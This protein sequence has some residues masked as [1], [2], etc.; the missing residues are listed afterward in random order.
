MDY[1]YINVLFILVQSR[2]TQKWNQ[3]ETWNIQM[4]L[5]FILLPPTLV[6]DR[7]TFCPIFPFYFFLY[8]QKF[9]FFYK[10]FLQFIL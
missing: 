9:H 1:F 6:E 4:A 8:L 2:E 3:I 7:S 5:E 10:D